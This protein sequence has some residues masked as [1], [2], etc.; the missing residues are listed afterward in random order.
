MSNSL[1]IIVTFQKLSNKFLLFTSVSK[2]IGYLDFLDIG[3][4][5][6]ELQRKYNE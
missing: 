1:N 6:I 2:I 3:K 4:L 5:L